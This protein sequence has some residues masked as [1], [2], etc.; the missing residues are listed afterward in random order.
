M[1][2]TAMRLPHG[3]DLIRA[4]RCVGYSGT[5][6]SSHGVATL[7]DSGASC[8]RAQDSGDTLQHRCDTFE[9]TLHMQHFLVHLH[10]FFLTITQLRHVQNPMQRSKPSLKEAAMPSTTTIRQDSIQWLEREST[11]L[12]PGSQYSTLFCRLYFTAT[13]IILTVMPPRR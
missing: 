5:C 1:G 2:T 11:W 6:E 7:V 9:H 4:D 3:W 13:T 12:R 8:I 10:T